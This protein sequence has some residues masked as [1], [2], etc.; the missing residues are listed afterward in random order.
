MVKFIIILSMFVATA[1]SSSIA[2][3]G[4][5][6]IVYGD[7][8]VLPTARITINFGPTKDS[9]VLTGQLK[10]GDTKHDYQV[11]VRS[12]GDKTFQGRGN[13]IVRIGVDS[14]VSSTPTEVLRCSYPLILTMK[15]LG[16][17]AN[18]KPIYEVWFQAPNLVPDMVDLSQGCPNGADYTDPTLL[19][20]PARFYML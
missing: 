12:V 3:A 14:S 15:Y 9:Y 11:V 4:E 13:Y 7:G 8:K 1:I 20:G 18:K 10:A 19:W 6:V 5:S 16:D 2:W 17:N